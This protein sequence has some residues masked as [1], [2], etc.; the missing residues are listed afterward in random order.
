MM[1]SAL[2]DHQARMGLF[3]LKGGHQVSLRIRARALS[4]QTIASVELIICLCAILVNLEKAV[5]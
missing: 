4:D 2:T 3:T 1:S 5:I